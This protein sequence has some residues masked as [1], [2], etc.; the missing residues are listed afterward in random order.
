MTVDTGVGND[1]ESIKRSLRYN[2][3]VQ[4]LLSTVHVN[5]KTFL[6]STGH[7][8]ITIVISYSKPQYLDS[9]GTLVNCHLHF[10]RYISLG[11]QGIILNNRVLQGMHCSSIVVAKSVLIVK[12]VDR[13]EHKC[14]TCI[15]QE[16]AATI[17]LCYQI[18]LFFM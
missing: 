11:L 12:C 14:N 17:R 13:H 9:K 4:L 16:E 1:S 18:F 6:L 2:L 10:S 8:K 5:I 7:V 15:K 3:T